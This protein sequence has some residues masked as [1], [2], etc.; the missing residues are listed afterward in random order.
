MAHLQLSLHIKNLTLGAKYIWYRRFNQLAL[1]GRHSHLN[2]EGQC[3]STFLLFSVKSFQQVNNTT[4]VLVLVRG[5][6]I[7]AGVVGG[8]GG[9]GSRRNHGASCSASVLP[10]T[11]PRWSDRSMCQLG[12]WWGWHSDRL[13][14]SLTDISGLT[15]SL[16]QLSFRDKR[17]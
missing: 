4:V 13:V 3:P 17:L 11:A 15:C 7:S 14:N 8:F 10:T 12:R 6:L 16:N 2:F 9:G 1:K 5:D